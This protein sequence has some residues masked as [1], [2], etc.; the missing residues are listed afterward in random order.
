MTLD[1][2]YGVR[3]PIQLMCVRGQKNGT[4]PQMVPFRVCGE[5]GIRTRVGVNPPAFQAGA[6]G[7]YATSP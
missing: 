6:L 1:T 5:G 4:H 7:L 2:G 3:V